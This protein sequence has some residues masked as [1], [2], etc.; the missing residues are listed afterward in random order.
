MRI[1]EYQA[2]QLL[3][4]AG[5]HT[6]AGFVADH[7]NVVPSRAKC[8]APPFMV[9][10]QVL[11]GGRGKRGLVTKVRSVPEAEATASRW[12]GSP[13]GADEAPVRRVLVEEAPDVASEHYVAFVLDRASGGPL[14]LMSSHAGADVEA[15]GPERF[16]LSAAGRADIPGRTVREAVRGLD[17]P[18][19]LAEE[20]ALVIRRLA[21]VFF[22][23]ECLLLEINPLAVTAGPRLTALDAKIEFD[24]AALFRHPELVPFRDAEGEGAE[25]AGPSRVPPVRLGGS[26]GLMVNGAGL[27]MATMDG[28]KLHGAES[29]NFLDMGGGASAEDVRAAMDWMLRNG[30]VRAV[31]VHI[32]GG[33]VKCDLAAEGMLLA[34]RG[35]SA[36]VR[37]P[38]VVRFAGTNSAE[39]LELLRNSGMDFVFADSF[40]EAVEKAAGLGK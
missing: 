15:A 21:S 7:S 27:S 5:I 32:F 36:S 35:V 19:S 26:V 34:V 9:K 14:L 12:I 30:N 31:L 8:M 2:K 40:R 23:K 20:A 16:P 28:L 17:L 29:A 38:V 39:G 11:A 18:D 4:A 22:G 6:P 24:D 33:I 1:Q 25:T 37:K 10:A 13:F 3:R